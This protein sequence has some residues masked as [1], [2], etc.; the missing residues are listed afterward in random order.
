MTIDDDIDLEKQL[1][2][3]NEECI[4]CY[5]NKNINEYIIFDCNH[6]VCIDCYVKLNKCP[7]CLR[8][9]NNRP[10]TIQSNIMSSNT[11]T[12]RATITSVE[13]RLNRENI[14]DRI[15]TER[16]YRII[17]VL[18]NSCCFFCI[19]FFILFT[20]LYSKYILDVDI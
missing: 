2:E 4:I 20:I 12:T 13:D 14:T 3:I 16:E 5:Y 17:N 7:I 9:F 18:C 11:S 15:N 10:L 1:V 6:K 19:T 8:P